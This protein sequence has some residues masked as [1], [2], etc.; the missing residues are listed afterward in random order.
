[1]AE[2][3]LEL[4][5]PKD[6]SV[7][8]GE[9][10]TSGIYE[11][12]ITCTNYSL[13]SAMEMDVTTNATRLMHTVNIENITLSRLVDSSSIPIMNAHFMGRSYPQAIIHFLVAAGDTEEKTTSQKEY[14]TITLDNVLIA[15]HSMS[16]DESSKGT[17][18]IALNF[19][20]I[21]LSYKYQDAKAGLSGTYSTSYDVQ[22]GTAG[23]TQS[24]S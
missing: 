24:G 3:V 9:C 4:Q 23:T 11:K 21:A 14:L 16:I 5:D 15:S 8:A 12:K 6:T 7:V 10:T 20:K 13:S 22:L 17:E 1:M 2:I 19:T 18:E